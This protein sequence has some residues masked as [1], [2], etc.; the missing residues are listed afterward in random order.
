MRSECCGHWLNDWFSRDPLWYFMCCYA[1]GWIVIRR[2][3]HTRPVPRHG[4]D[5]PFSL[6]FKIAAIIAVS[7]LSATIIAA[8]ASGWRESERRFATKLGELEGIAAAL[9]VTVEPALANNDKRRTQDALRAIGRIAAVRSAEVRNGQGT[10]VAWFGNNVVVTSTT[11]AAVKADPQSGRFS[12]S[13]YPIEAAVVSGGRRIGTLTIVADISDLRR[14]LWESLSAALLAGLAAAGVGFTLAMGLE[15]IATAPIR[16]LM[17]AMRH[18]RTTADF[19]RRVERTSKDEVGELVDAFNAML[20]EI[21]DRDQSLRRHSETL[22]QTVIDRTRE[23]ATAKAAAEAANAAKSEFLATM[24]HEIRTPMN[25]MLVMAELLA[26]RELEPGLQRYADVIVSSGRSLLAIINDILDLS[27]VESGRLELERIPIDPAGIADDVARIF[28]ERA[29]SKGLDLAVIAA[30]DLPRSVVGDPVRLTQIISNFVNNALKFTE[31]G[32]VSIELSMSGRPYATDGG[33]QGLRIAVTDTGVGI[34]QDKLG[35]I[36]EAFAQA[37]SSIARSHGGTGIGLAICQRLVRAMRGEIQVTSTVGRGS[38][39][40]FEIDCEVL[41]PAEA[42]VTTS[43]GD[44]KRVIALMIEGEPTRRAIQVA[45]DWAGLSTVMLDPRRPDRTALR[46]A[47]AVIADAGLLHDVDEWLEDAT[48]IVALEPLGEAT[49]AAQRPPFQAQISITRPLTSADA[50]EAMRFASGRPI[51]DRGRSSAGV[52]GAPRQNFLDVRVLAADDSAVNREVLAEVLRRLGV[53]VVSVENGA[54]AVEAWERGHFDL[55]FMDGSMPV[56]DGFD[57]CRAIREREASTGRS[58][59][60][61]IALTAY[62]VGPH[63]DTWRNAGMNDCVTKPFTLAAIET[64]VAR[65]VHPQK[66]SGAVA[67]DERSP[68]PQEPGP[69]E[70]VSA[71]PVPAVLD[72]EILRSIALMAG[73]ASSLVERVV[74]LFAEH[75]P[76]AAH[77]LKAAIASCDADAVGREAHALKSMCRNVGATRLADWLERVEHAAGQGHVPDQAVSDEALGVTLRESLAAR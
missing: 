57:A 49:A 2:S 5:M 19:E 8:L 15:R 3:W 58:P 48:R 11:A 50:R 36:F 65:W 22:E 31:R 38:C 40:S 37:D 73:P 45:A 41:A 46:D 14:A 54:E 33:S 68:G 23:L 64:C 52:S 47:G 16:S 1:V 20:A 51:G 77:R 66:V 42:L 26:A 17:D 69:Q 39:F 4:S 43:D 32:S 7:I 76:T 44:T 34:P 6:R 12:L 18:I 70:G 75:A 10:V 62:V 27:K 61:V 72:D 30:P 25:G 74:T 21:R 13:T 9:A 53:D 35:Q 24:S 60:P 28:A 29:A 59:V 56:L 67:E 55:V 63:A 71:V